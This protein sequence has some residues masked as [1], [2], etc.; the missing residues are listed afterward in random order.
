MKEE[1]VSMIDK[2]AKQYAGS[3]YIKNHQPKIYDERFNAYIAGRSKSIES[4]KAKDE[5]IKSLEAGLNTLRHGLF[6]NVD[7]VNEFIDNLLN[8]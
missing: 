4:E 2:E 5:R 3:N 7:A 8:K 6:K 1:L